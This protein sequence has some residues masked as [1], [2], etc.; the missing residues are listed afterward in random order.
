[1]QKYFDILGITP[2]TTYDEARK[3]YHGLLKK[4][5]PDKGGNKESTQKIIEAWNHVKEF[6]R[7]NKPDN[8]NTSKVVFSNFEEFEYK[9]FIKRN[10]PTSDWN[11]KTLH[12]TYCPRT[13]I[14]K[15]YRN[16][17]Y[18]NS[19]FL[20]LFAY[21]FDY[22]E[23]EGQAYWYYFQSDFQ[24]KN[25]KGLS[26]DSQKFFGEIKPG[27]NY[28]IKINFDDNKEGV[29]KHYIYPKP[30]GGYNINL[31]KSDIFRSNYEEKEENNINKETIFICSVCKSEQ[32]EST[33][34]NKNPIFY[35][36]ICNEERKFS[37]KKY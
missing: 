29:V 23:N 1:M 13:K 20:M 28:N 4:Y 19:F 9:S 33:Y 15:V 22:S 6:L 35:C 36:P 14:P 12:F 7:K 2:S 8:N 34:L 32:W 3:K 10:I 25:I 5:H 21:Y 16:K 37:Q 17:D 26:E 27:V 24:I 11:L 18:G 31:K 30:G